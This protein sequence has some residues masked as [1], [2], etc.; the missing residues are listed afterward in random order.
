MKWEWVG[1]ASVCNLYNRETWESSSG[2]GTAFP[3]L[4]LHINMLRDLKKD[5]GRFSLQVLRADA[6]SWGG[7]LLSSSVQCWVTQF[8][9]TAIE[10]FVPVAPLQ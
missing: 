3:P 10:T 9:V 4:S 2:E 7:G 8:L 6:P 5:P 1:S